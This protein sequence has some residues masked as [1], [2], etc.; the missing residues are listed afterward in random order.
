MLGPP[1]GNGADGDNTTIANPFITTI[2]ANG[3][4]GGAGDNT[5]GRD[6]GSGGGSAEMI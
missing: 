4:G 6:G 3:G 1:S 5:L 2:T